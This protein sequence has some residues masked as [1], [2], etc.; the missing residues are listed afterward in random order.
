MS[1][2]IIRDSASGDTTIV[3][4]PGFMTVHLFLSIFALYLC[5]RCNGEFRILPFLAA[6][7]FPYLYIPYA[8]AITCRDTTI[9][10]RF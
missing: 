10:P 7:F 3:F 6:L 9:F 5:F 2:S 8:L 1:D 4:G